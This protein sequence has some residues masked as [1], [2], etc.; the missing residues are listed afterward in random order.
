M[1]K[2]LL[3]LTFLLSVFTFAQ[4]QVVHYISTGCLNIPGNSTQDYIITGYTTSN[5]V[6][7]QPGYK[8][9]I[10]LRNLTIKLSSGYMSPIT[11][12]GENNRSN[13]NPIS[14]VDII[15]EGTN[16]LEYSGVVTTTTERLSGAAVIQVDQGTQINISAID[17]NNNASGILSAIQANDNGGAAIGAR[18]AAGSPINSEA[19]ASSIQTSCSSSD[20]TTGGNIV[21]SSGTITAKGG[22]GAG[23]GGGF[24][25]YYDGMIVIYGGIVNASC[26]YHAAGIGSGCPNGHGVESCYTPNSAIIVLPPAQITA[27]GAQSSG[28]QR[29]DLALAGANNIVYIGDPAKPL[30]TVHTEDYEPN[31]NIYVDLS[32]NPNIAK[33]VRAT[34]PSDRLDIHQVKFGK[35]N[36]SG[37]YSFH[38]ILQDITTFFTDARSSKPGTLGRPYMPEAR[39]LLNG[40][41]IELDLL[42]A[43]FS[44]TSFPS[45]PLDKGYTKEQAQNAAY[46]VKL[47]YTDPLPMSNVKFDLANGTDSDFDNL[48]FLASDRITPVSM[49]TN[50]KQGDVYYIIVP[51]KQGKNT[52]EY[53]DVLRLIGQWCGKSTGYIRTI[54]NQVV[55]EATV[56][57]ICNGESYLFEG[58]YYNR[59]GRYEVKCKDSHGND[60]I[61]VLNLTVHPSYNQQEV[62]TICENELPYTW[63]DVRLDVGTKTGTYI[64]D[65]TSVYGCDST[66]NLDLT[67]HP[68]YN[69]ADTL[70]LCSQDLPY[71]WRDT[72]FAAG[73]TSNDFTFH[74]TTI[75]GCDSIVNLHLIVNSTYKDTIDMV[76]C[77]NELPYTW[78]D[79]TFAVGTTSGE[80]IFTRSTINGCDSIVTLNLTVQSMYNHTETETICQNE[81]PYTWR[82]T[83]FDVGTNSGEYIFTR[84]TINGCDSV[85]TLNLTVQSMYNLTE[86]ETICQNELPY[87]WRDTTFAVGTMSGEYVFTRSTMNGCDSV[88]TLNLIVQSMYNLTE[89]ETICQN[90]LPYTW[91]DT[92]F[93]VGTTSGEY[94]FTR[95][96]VNGCDSVVTLNL[97][98]LPIY[99]HTETETICQNELP[100]TWRDTTFAVGTNSGEYIFTRS[101]VN[102][103]DSVVTLNLTVHPIYNH[104]ETETICQNEL[105]YT[106][107]DTTFDVGTNSGEYIFTR[108]TMN[109]CDSVVTLNLTVH[110]MYNHTET[111]TICQN[112]LPYTWRDTTFA[113]GTT[114]GEYIFTRST[115]N[116]CDSVVTLQ[117]TVNPN[118]NQTESLVLCQQELPY[119]WRDTTFDVGTMSGNIVFKR[120]TIHG[121][122]SIVTLNL[123]VNRSYKQQEKLTLCPCDLPYVWRGHT[124]DDSMPNGTYTFTELTTNGCDSIVELELYVHPDKTM[125]EVISICPS[126]L[127]YAWRDTIFDIGTTSGTYVF[128][129]KTAYNCDS[130][131]T[132]NLTVFPSVDE[133]VSLSICQNELPYTWRDTT[134][135]EGTMSGNIV[136][137]HQTIHGCDSVVTLMLTVNRTYEEEVQLTLCQSDLP[138]YWRGHEI[139]ALMESG[140]YIF[141][142]TTINGCDSIVKLSLYIRPRE[143][144]QEQITICQSELPYL[145]RDTVFDASTT[146][147]TYTIQ[148]QN[149]FGCET[150]HTLTL[151]VNDTMQ[152]H[153]YDS[154]YVDS[155]Y[156]K[157]NFDYT[158][159]QGLDYIELYQNLT[160]INQCDSIVTLHLHVLNPPFV[161]TLGEISN[162]C[163]DQQSFD[164]PFSFTDYRFNPEIVEVR[165]DVSARAVGFADYRQVYN[166][167][168]VTIPIP[169]AVTP[170]I[171]SGTI[172][173][174]TDKFAQGLGFEF[175]IRYSSSVIEQHWNDVLALRNE[176]LNGGYYFEEYQWYKNGEPLYAETGSYLY[177][178]PYDELDMGAE[179]SVLIRRRGEENQVFTCPVIPTYHIDVQDFPTLVE[180]ST[181]LKLPIRQ[182]TEVYVYNTTGQ[183]VLH[184]TL[185]NDDMEII[186]PNASGT[187]I[188]QLVT[189]QAD[190]VTYKMIVK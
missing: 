49:P 112:E 43:N 3:V 21:I 180:H 155:T 1:Q 165:F 58:R 81:L 84:S 153:I 27:Y 52:G 50:F 182:Q 29:P 76:I 5:Y 31:A 101:T 160:N 73:T 144:T 63:R 158:P 187:Y 185:T 25:Y 26:I 67:V 80:Y 122:D 123:V 39:I 150:T 125:Q 178:G 126:E 56:A 19:Y 35:T 54:V 181:P 135:A 149:E 94:I 64:Y 162:I 188:V 51:I 164:I 186:T 172:N 131:V 48:L 74:R 139:D 65:R 60:S 66:V 114:S 70:V 16:Y 167:N 118:Y 105:P 36:A 8:G 161:A 95:S 30:V 82:D 75:N 17:P 145:W 87:T 23:I 132:L 111:E 146:S 113:V 57:N 154:V 47:T 55:L 128:N 147:G 7:V 117:L 152:I 169:T 9:K 4:A 100:Y 163:A 22:H 12:H 136:F 46:C 173:L 72:V 79:T 174:Y 34:V 83:T 45:V 10:T 77:Q 166:G 71:T 175:M 116:G 151:H 171:Y 99:N 130:I 41:D 61:V 14:N 97:T 189:N 44:L 68:S 15:L 2:K 96:T 104:T 18:D 20:R 78:R 120:Q 93:A 13:L 129:R 33:V 121:C 179:Y 119:T 62:L 134:F 156:N 91:R 127:P 90:E 141:N 108:S 85:V 88:V 157:Y 92:M 170:D 102:G 184:K 89:T 98:V 37:I 40:A 143:D 159:P 148:R 142:E 140:E 115:V 109:G 133:K 124:I 53:S 24:C 69:Q 11:F 168:F 183:L 28:T 59:T 176:T 138:Y 107:R 42:L 38:G 190:V 177:V 6:E 137:K 110:P 106:W 103:C 86:T 32:Q